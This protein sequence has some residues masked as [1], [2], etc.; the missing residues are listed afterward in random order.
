MADAPIHALC[1]APAD[2]PAAGAYWAYAAA[3]KGGV[4]LVT[5]RG[6]VACNAWRKPR[7]DLG[8]CSA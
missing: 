5:R 3:H 4:L 6:E 1:G 8:V 2:L 7:Q